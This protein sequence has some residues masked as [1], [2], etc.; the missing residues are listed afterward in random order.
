MS[1]DS[2][3]GLQFRYNI[4]TILTKYRDIDMISIFCKCVRYTSIRT[5]TRHEQGNML[6]LDNKN[7]CLSD[8]YCCSVNNSSIFSYSP[9]EITTESGNYKYWK[10]LNIWRKNAQVLTPILLLLLLVPWLITVGAKHNLPPCLL[11]L[12]QSNSF[13]QCQLSPLGDVVCPLLWRS[14]SLLYTANWAQQ[15]FLY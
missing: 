4:D 1:D 3:S 5:V 6:Y 15:H 14:S 9:Y 12:R 8:S 13:T 10:A 11:I 2:I 7:V